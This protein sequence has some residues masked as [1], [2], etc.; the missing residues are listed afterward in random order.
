MPNKCFLLQT[1]LP[2]LS[3]V[4]KSL[5]VPHGLCWQNK[6][7]P[8]YVMTAFQISQMLVANDQRTDFGD[9]IF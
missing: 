3:V 8:N 7:R 6:V 5:H 1:V 2:W 4:L 9:L